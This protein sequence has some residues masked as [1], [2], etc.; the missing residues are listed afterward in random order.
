MVF[1][2]QIY[3]YIFKNDKFKL[4]FT[5]WLF[6]WIIYFTMLII[7]KC[8]LFNSKCFKKNQTSLYNF[9]RSVILFCYFSYL[10]KNKI[11]E[12]FFP[13]FFQ[14]LVLIK[15]SAYRIVIPEVLFVKTNE[16]LFKNLRDVEGRKDCVGWMM[17][18]IGQ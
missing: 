9:F 14:I 4:T 8:L 15:G 13:Y 1:D 3:I 17:T 12:Q 11:W 6:I 10:N 18:Y 5:F 7:N 2:L 16:K